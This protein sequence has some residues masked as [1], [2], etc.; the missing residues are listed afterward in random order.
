MWDITGNS[1]LSNPRSSSWEDLE[2]WQASDRVY[3]SGPTKEAVPET[4]GYLT[5]WLLTKLV[6]VYNK[7]TDYICVLVDFIEKPGY[8]V[9]LSVGACESTSFGE[10]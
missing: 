6:C 10:S 1:P 2:S 4:R 8:F 7:I 5:I 3:N 9:G